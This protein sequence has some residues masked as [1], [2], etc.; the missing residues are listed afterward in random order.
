MIPSRP[1]PPS[2]L[3]LR[4]R[5]VLEQ[6]KDTLKSSPAMQAARTRANVAIQRL[7]S[8]PLSGEPVVQAIQRYIQ[9]LLDRG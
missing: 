4:P 1:G 5:D 3:P 7:Q 6:A 9:D 2:K 8:S